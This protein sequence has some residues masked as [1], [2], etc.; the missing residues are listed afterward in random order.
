M[1][2]D[3]KVAMGGL[4]ERVRESLHELEGRGEKARKAV[5]RFVG[6]AKRE[7]KRE[8][9]SSR[10][11]LEGELHKTTAYVR[12][13]VDEAV[14]GSIEKIW[15]PTKRAIDESQK[16]LDRLE[17]KMEAMAR[18]APR[19]RAAAKPRARTTKRAAARR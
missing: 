1:K 15:A 11:T 6:K 17:R 3:L 12:D 4:E 7:V 18:P 13:M 19:K 14:K 9:K 16:R 5:K 10:R 8:V 2:R